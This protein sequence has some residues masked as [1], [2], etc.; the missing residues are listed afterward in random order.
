MSDC[1]CKADRTPNAFGATLAG[2]VADEH[3]QHIHGEK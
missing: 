3:Y 2:A 1:F